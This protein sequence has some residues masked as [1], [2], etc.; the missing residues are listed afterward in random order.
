VVRRALQ[1]SRGTIRPEL[2]DE[3]L[4]DPSAL[5]SLAEFGI[6]GANINLDSSRRRGALLEWRWQALQRLGLGGSYTWTDA[7]ITAG[8]FDGN[9]VPYVAE[10]VGALNATWDFGAG[11]SAFAEYAWNGSRYA[12]GDDARAGRAEHG[13]ALGLGAD[14]TCARTTSTTR[15]RFAH[16]HH[17]ASSVTARAH[18]VPY[19]RLCTQ[20]CGSGEWGGSA[21][22]RIC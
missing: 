2:D 22:G 14:A 20:T 12:L 5:G 13:A 18:H 11:F 1:R 21:V 19:A 6:F 17:T 8:T 4:Y 15:P 3:I 7:E 16:Q 10:H 9:E